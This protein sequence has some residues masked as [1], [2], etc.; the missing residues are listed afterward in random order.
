M[1]LNGV[2]TKAVNAL[3]LS[4]RAQAI[5]E[6]ETAA[7]TCSIRAPRCCWPTA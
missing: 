6:D 3:S 1:G 4:Y 2:G 5:R 7:L